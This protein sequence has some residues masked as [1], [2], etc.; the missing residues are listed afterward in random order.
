[1]YREMVRELKLEMRRILKTAMIQLNF[2][3]DS[4]LLMLLFNRDLIICSRHCFILTLL[5]I[6]KWFICKSPPAVPASCMHVPSQG[7]HFSSVFFRTY[8]DGLKNVD[9]S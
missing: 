3:G 6:H 8:S 7:D 2:L 9:F 4:W 5:K 1:M